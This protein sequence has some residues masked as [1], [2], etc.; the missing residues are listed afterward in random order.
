[1]SPGGACG[2]GPRGIRKLRRRSRVVAAEKA[3][4]LTGELG[5]GR[6]N[7]C[8]TRSSLVG[9]V[10]VITGEVSDPNTLEMLAREAVPH[11]PRNRIMTD[12]WGSLQTLLGFAP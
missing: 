5:A 9:R 4:V 2:H 3:G 11:V 7:S 10:L 12:L 6:M 8:R 1:M